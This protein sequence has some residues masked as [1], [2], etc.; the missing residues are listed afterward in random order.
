L[1]EKYPSR[2]HWGQLRSLQ[3]RLQQW[4]A[5]SGPNKE[6]I[7]RQVIKPGKQSQC[8][9]TCMNGLKIE[10][11]GEIF[12][13]LLFHFMLP[14]SKWESIM[15]CHSES[16]ETLTQGYEKAVWKLGGVLPEHR[17]DNLSAAT[18]K[19]GS[20]REFTE[21]WQEFLGFYKV[22]PSRNNPG[23]SHEN[24]SVEKSHD[25]LKTAI[26]QHLLL[27]GSRSFISLEEY[28]QFLENIIQKRNQGREKSLA[29][30]IPLLKSLPNRKYN[31]PII[32][33]VRVSPSS[34]VQ[35]LGVTYSVPSRLIS[36]TLKAYVYGNEIDLYYGQKRLQKLPRLSNGAL[37]NY[38]HI[39]DS[40]VRKPN[41]FAHY[42]YR[43]CLFPHILFREAYD[44]LVKSHPETGHKHYLK[45]LQLAKIH[46]EQ[47]VLTALQLLEEEQKIPLPE[48]VKS[49]LDSSFKPV[50]MVQVF[51]P[52][53][54][55]YD[56][57]HTFQK[58]EIAV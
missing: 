39:I 18:Q 41:A 44:Q 35:I 37:V 15:I 40:L 4:R 25:L 38:A 8:D 16:F 48:E 36:Y 29:E 54:A 50:V 28:E 21:R 1:I 6:V 43:D 24:G 22:T 55:D 46:G 51:Q 11:A 27:R 52:C 57:L 32:L 7:F 13:H 3:R 45:L 26:D 30:E 49:L 17:T 42:Q 2:Y 23:N 14:Y 20:S 58:Q 34:T 9:W 12:H 10:I 31:A 19:L 33:P 47:D 56:T 53:L 5:E